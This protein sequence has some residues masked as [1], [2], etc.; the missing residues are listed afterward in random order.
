MNENEN[1]VQ[2][3]KVDL[4]EVI[5]LLKKISLGAKPADCPEKLAIVIAKNAEKYPMAFISHCFPVG[6]ILKWKGGTLWENETIDQFVPEGDLL[7]YKLES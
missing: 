5:A 1:T 3:S 4:D 6:A 2:V 7:I